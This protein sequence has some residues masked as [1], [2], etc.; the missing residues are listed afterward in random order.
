MP[1][2]ETLGEPQSG[3]YNRI[4]EVPEYIEGFLLHGN[5]VAERYAYE[6]AVKK[7]PEKRVRRKEDEEEKE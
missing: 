2:F 5:E 7:A 4:G 3:P 6:A 1:V